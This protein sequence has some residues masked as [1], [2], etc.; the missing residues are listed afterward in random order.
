MLVLSLAEGPVLSLRR[1]AHHFALRHL[2]AHVPQC[3]DVLTLPVAVI[4]LADLEQQVWLAAYLG[5]P[6][7]K[8][9]VQ[10]AAAN[11]PQA[12]VFADVLDAN[13]DVTYGFG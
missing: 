5:P 10:G 12:V 9:I 7:L 3:P 8:I 2:K 11:Q 13:G 6:A 4:L 1:N